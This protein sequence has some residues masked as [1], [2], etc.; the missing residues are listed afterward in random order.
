MKKMKRMGKDSVD[1]PDP[2]KLEPVEVEEEVEEKEEDV[3]EPFDC[4]WRMLIVGI[5]STC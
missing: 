1:A 4:I 2:A 3:S 5:G